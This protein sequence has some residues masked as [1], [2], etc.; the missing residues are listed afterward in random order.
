MGVFPVTLEESTALEES[1]VAERQ[2]ASALDRGAVCRD[3]VTKACCLSV[4]HIKVPET[5]TLPMDLWKSVQS[6]T[7]GKATPPLQP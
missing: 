6:G 2:N 5:R 7:W 3:R 4:C 1:R